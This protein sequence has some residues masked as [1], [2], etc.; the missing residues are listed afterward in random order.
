MASWVL[1]IS[2]VLVG[3][4]GEEERGWGKCMG[5]VGDGDSDDSGKSFV[6]VWFLEIHPQKIAHYLFRTYANY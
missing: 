2:G 3:E 1:G 6:G 4:A 5:R